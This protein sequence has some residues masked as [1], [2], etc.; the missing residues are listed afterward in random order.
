LCCVDEP[1]LPKLPPRIVEVTSDVGYVRF[2]GRATE[3]WWKHKEA[4]QQPPS[5][6]G[7]SQCVHVET[8]L[9]PP[10]RDG[11][12]N[13]RRALS[14]PQGFQ[15]RGVR[16][17]AAAP[18]ITARSRSNRLDEINLPC[19]RTQISE[20]ASAPSP[21]DRPVARVGRLCYGRSHDR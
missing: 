7:T 18:V 5:R 15:P 21:G 3:T 19:T 14:R 1:E 12:E 17:R 4:S 13:P 11:S 2:H 6:Q 10:C 9:G 8:S 20:A 16:P